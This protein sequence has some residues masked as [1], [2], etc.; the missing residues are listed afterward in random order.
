MKYQYKCTK[1]ETIFDV[2]MA[3]KDVINTARFPKRACPKCG[4]IARKAI[5]QANIRFKGAGFY[6]TDN[7]K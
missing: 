1:C 7:K 6:S 3:L 2:N 4:G 5:T